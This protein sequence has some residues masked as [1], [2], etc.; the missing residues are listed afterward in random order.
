V[1]RA[2]LR[3]GN[4]SLVAT[5]ALAGLAA[6]GPSGLAAAQARSSFG[7][8]VTLTI[9][10]DLFGTPPPGVS[11]AN[12]WPNKALQLFQQQYPNIKVKV[13]ATPQDAQSAFATLLKSSEVAGNTPDVGG[14]FAGGQILQNTDYLLQLNKYVSPAFKG[15]L[16]T[17]WQFATAGFKNSGP[18]YGVPYGAGYYYFVYYNKALFKKAGISTSALPTTW[19]G[20]ITLA[21]QVK[22]KG[23]LPFQFGEKDGYYGAWTQDALISG[24]VGTQGVLSMFAGK[25]SLNSPTIIRAYTAWHELD[26]DGLTNA[27]ALSLDNNQS[28]AQFAAGNGAMTITGGFANGSLE[29][30]AMKPNIG[31]FPV[32]ALPG[33]KYPKI[34]SGGPNN[35]YVIFKNTKYPEQAMD[36]VKYLVS[37]KVQEMA[38]DQGFGQLP[39]NTAYVAGPSLKT[40]DPVLAETYQYIRVQHY[41]LAE[42]FDNIMPGSID[43]YWYQTNSGVFGGSLSPS[44]A[45]KSLE[46]Q[47]QNYLATSSS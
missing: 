46:Q 23:I 28:F 10:N 24:E 19:P 16:Y 39:D 7:S 22:A 25:L 37:T 11:N 33:A 29:V 4:A 1:K 27:D 13:I 9:W 35:D 34:L 6:V 12:F 15:S 8:T 43:S 3:A 26:A 14:L 18:I 30:G 5:L 45:A 32:P 17:G 44:S 36:L 42:A 40:V 38:L 2:F 47:E 21:K 41:Q 20:L 31:I